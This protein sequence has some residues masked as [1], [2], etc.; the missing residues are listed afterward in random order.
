[1]FIPKIFLPIHIIFA[2]LED[3][4]LPLLLENLEKISHDIVL[5]TFDNKRAR[6]ENDYFIYLED[7]PFTNDYVLLLKKYREL[8]KEDIILFVGSIAFIDE[9]RKRL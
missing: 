3:K 1:M 4:N 9:V 7:F 6:T 2:C 5:T 8:Y